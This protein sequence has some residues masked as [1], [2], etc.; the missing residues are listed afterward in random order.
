MIDQKDKRI[1]ELEAEC[2][3]YRAAYA[4]KLDEHQVTLA[5][6]QQLCESRDNLANEKQRLEAALETERRAYADTVTERDAEGR[7]VERLEA[8]VSR[9]RAVAEA[10]RNLHKHLKQYTA[11]TCGC[12]MCVAGRELRE[13]LAKLEEK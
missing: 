5:Q 10:A 8:E 1:A 13:A 3:H 11:K 2:K 12:T 4:R 6:A 9:L 7:E